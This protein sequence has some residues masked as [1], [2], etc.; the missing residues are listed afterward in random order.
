MSFSQ[1]ALRWLLDQRMAAMVC[2][3]RVS[4]GEIGKAHLQLQ[5]HPGF[6]H[7]SHTLQAHLVNNQ[8]TTQAIAATVNR[9]ENEHWYRTWRQAA[10]G[11]PRFYTYVYYTD[12]RQLPGPGQP[13]LNPPTF[14]E[15]CSDIV[16]VGKGTGNRA[17]EH[18][19][20]AAAHLPS[21]PGNPQPG[22]IIPPFH[23]FILNSGQNHLLTQVVVMPNTIEKIAEDREG[24]ILWALGGNVTLNNPGNPRLFNDQDAKITTYLLRKPRGTAT[25]VAEFCELGIHYLRAAYHQL[26]QPNMSVIVKY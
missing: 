14:G 12:T 7:L 19:S 6:Q 25:A 21:N 11:I 20:L 8:P 13:A 22:Q 23:Q 9:I 18:F 1:G 4:G 26:Y 16:Y 24:A 3:E 2:S 10:Q 15:F 17:L 5:Q